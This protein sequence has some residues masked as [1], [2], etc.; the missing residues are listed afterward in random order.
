M[1]SLDSHLQVFNTVTGLSESM[2]DKLL[3]RLKLHYAL[4]AKH[5]DITQLIQDVAIPGLLIHDEH[6]RLIPIEV[7]YR[8]A[9]VWNGSRIIKT[10][11]L[12]HRKI[13]K[14]PFVI[15]QVINYMLEPS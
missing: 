1:K 2:M 6:D 8:I 4:E 3:I 10:Q 15:H 14:D 12:G 7:A 11:K 9:S 13:L 5:T